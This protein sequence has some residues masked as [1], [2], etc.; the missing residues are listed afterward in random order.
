M[1]GFFGVA[2]KENCVND[3]FFG[4]DYHCHLGTRRGGMAVWSEEDGFERAIHNIENA[5]FR[6]KFENDLPTMKGNLGI[7]VISDTEPQPMLVRSHLGEFAIVTVGRINNID[8]LTQK[9]YTAGT[10]QFLEM[11]GGKINPTELTAWLINSQASIAD[12]IRYA[13]QSIEGSMSM[14]VMTA[15]GIYAARDYQGRTPVIIGQKAGA[16]CAA[17]ESSSFLNLGY[18]HLRDLGPGEI[19][20]ITPEGAETLKKPLQKMRICTFLWVYFG[21]PSS[22]YEGINV[23]AMRNRC[24]AMLAK[25]DSVTADTVSGV[26]D[27]GVAHAIGYSNASG[28]PYSRPYIKYTPTWPRSFMPQ[29]QS[30][31]NL[32]AQMKLIPIEDMIRGKSLIMVDDSLVRGTQ[33]K[34]T[35]KFLFNTGAKDV[36]V[37]LACPPILFG[38][39]YLNFSRSTSDMDLI[40][41]RIIAR[42]EGENSEQR[43]DAYADPD[44]PEYKAMIDAICQEQGFSSLRYHRLDD[45]VASTQLPACSLCTYCWNGKE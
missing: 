44:S 18:R 14:L 25:R 12:G 36:H 21:Y 22:T 20:F 17:S 33:M 10:S 42:M 39:K 24:G 4:T 27:S 45:L 8:E 5:P 3:V 6:T 41:R 28:I 43:L 9:A 1:G 13:Q 23:E 15:K 11:S 37:R 2:G 35:A 7:G 34:G 29:H 26:P 32:I 16:V 31:R 19:A 40:A 38:C 30:Q